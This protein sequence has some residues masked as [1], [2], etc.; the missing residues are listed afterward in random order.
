MRMVNAHRRCAPK[1]VNNQ[2]NHQK[3]Q[4]QISTNK[5][6]LT[7][8]MPHSNKISSELLYFK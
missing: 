6:V 4:E 1:P 8:L 3:L 5:S 2:W 7:W